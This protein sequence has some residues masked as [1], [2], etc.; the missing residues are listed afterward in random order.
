MKNQDSLEFQG[1][2]AGLGSSMAISD[3]YVRQQG[4][5]LMIE[6]PEQI[7]HDPKGKASMS[8]PTLIDR[9]AHL[10][11]LPSTD[12]RNPLLAALGELLGSLDQLREGS[13]CIGRSVERWEG[14]GAVYLEVALPGI[15][16]AEVNINVHEGRVFIRMEGQGIRPGPPHG[17][18]RPKARRKRR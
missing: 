4:P 15:D 16:G 18:D 10:R 5:D 13:A 11:R 12:P 17:S 14:D 7:R 2:L 8:L 1:E 3:C 6:K 9:P